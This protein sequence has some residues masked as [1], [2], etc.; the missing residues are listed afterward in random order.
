M[1]ERERAAV[2]RDLAIGFGIAIAIALAL[3]L[4]GCGGGGSGG[5][6]TATARQGTP[7]KPLGHGSLTRRCDVVFDGPGPRDWRDGSDWIGPLGFAGRGPGPNFAEGSTGEDGVYMIKTPT[8][9]EGHRSVTIY[10]RPAEARRAGLL[11]VHP[12]PA[13]A[14]VTYVP[15]ADKP[16][17][18]FAAG[19][20]LRDRRRPI[21]LMVRVGDG[22]VESLAVGGSGHAREAA[23]AAGAPALRAAVVRGARRDFEGGTGAGPAGFP[24]CLAA[25]LRRALGVPRL[26]QLVSV[27]RRQGQPYASQAL[28]RL[29]VPIGDRCGSRRF[30]PELIAA[31]A[32]LGG[33]P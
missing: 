15:C 19:F 11:G 12:E 26:T 18:V 6:D 29:A 32:A 4:L 5:E 21:L 13:Y 3:L 8:L 1:D 27:Y 23:I 25:G 24:G 14:S 30:V 31:G 28:N 7:P 2:R 33:S 20:V 17:T 9:V 10:L 22:P 16:R